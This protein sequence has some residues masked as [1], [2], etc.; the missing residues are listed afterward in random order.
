MTDNP[1]AVPADLTESEPA[2]E[3]TPFPSLP[4]TI[5][6]SFRVDEPTFRRAVKK[7]QRLLPPD[8]RTGKRPHQTGPVANFILL[9]FFLV[10][11]PATF[12]IPRQFPLNQ[13]DRILFYVCVLGI[14]Y[15][16]VIGVF[17]DGKRRAN[18]MDQFRPYE[19]D[20]YTVEFG[21][22]NITAR[23]TDSEGYV[24][25]TISAWS[26]THV[27]VSKDAWFFN[28]HVTPLI[29]PRHELTE[30]QQQD[31]NEF[32]DRLVVWQNENRRPLKSSQPTSLP[33]IPADAIPFTMDSEAV[34]TV[35]SRM[36]DL[37]RIFSEC[38]WDI[39][40]S[41]WWGMLVLNVAA[42]LV[43]PIYRLFQSAPVAYLG[44][45]INGFAI[46]LFAKVVRSFSGSETPLF[47]GGF[48]RDELWLR[49]P[50]TVTHG[51]IERF[52]DNA[53]MD[54][55]LLINIKSDEPVTV[56]PATAFRT[57]EEFEEVGKLLA[58]RRVE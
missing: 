49:L 28:R 10:I 34:K 40:P 8:P 36:G 18:R 5:R 25:T 23:S 13:I 15:L 42:G 26:H 1:Y 35:L 27:E 4:E 45:G 7:C 47:Q 3:M 11:I 51:P 24:Q 12:A 53:I 19:V 54:D 43:H 44:L 22:H 31:M 29:V 48:T 52:R 9:A 14:P 21:P 16:S 32:V 6:V 55:L 46:W 41:L 57:H 2:A 56:T 30:E 17:V 37:R 58:A 38:R 39:F 50:Q 20:N 33:D